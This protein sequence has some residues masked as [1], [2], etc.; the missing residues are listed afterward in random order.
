MSSYSSVQQQMQYMEGV[1][2]DDG[3]TFLGD[4][5]SVPAQYRPSNLNTPG[6]APQPGLPTSGPMNIQQQQQPIMFNGAVLPNNNLNAA[7]NNYQLVGMPTSSSPSLSLNGGHT[8]TTSGTGMP[9]PSLLPEPTQFYQGPPIAPSS[10]QTT[11]FTPGNDRELG[12][13]SIMSNRL[14]IS[15]HHQQPD[16]AKSMPVLESSAKPAGSIKHTT[17]TLDMSLTKNNNALYHPSASGFDIDNSARPSSTTVASPPNTYVQSAITQ[18]SVGDISSTP[19]ASNN[20]A[21]VCDVREPQWSIK[22]I[23]PCVKNTVI[24]IGKDMQHLQT[25]PPAMVSGPGLNKKMGFVFT[26]DDRP[27]YLAILAVGVLLAVFVVRAI[28]FRGRHRSHSTTS[29]AYST[30]PMCVAHKTTAVPTITY[31]PI[32]TSSHV[33]PTTTSIV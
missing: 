14:P 31:K 11:A 3:F 33:I 15:H 12:N 18:R 1:D 10:V 20:S 16:L 28:L 4:D 32:S 21:L 13:N 6:I 8:P 7:Q 19:V 30:A 22:N 2:V 29:S 5:G 26:R 24:G 25:L 17:V 27:L 9:F 23:A